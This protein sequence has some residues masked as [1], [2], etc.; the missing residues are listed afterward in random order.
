MGSSAAI[1][2]KYVFN[3]YMIQNAYQGEVQG[4]CFLTLKSHPYIACN[5]RRVSFSL[6]WS[7]IIIYGLVRECVKLSLSLGRYL[8]IRSGSR[9]YT[10]VTGISCR[11]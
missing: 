1:T 9:L 8:Y 7:Q 6:K 5:D 11:H 3:T 4:D 10:Q 2:W